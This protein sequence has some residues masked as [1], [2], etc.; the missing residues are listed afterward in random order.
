MRGMG[1]GQG[2]VSGSAAFWASCATAAPAIAANANSATV[3][4]A[5]MRFPLVRFALPSLIDQ[6]YSRQAKLQDRGCAISGRR[7]E[8]NYFE[9]GRAIV[10]WLLRK[11]LE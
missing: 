11:Q 2:V 3:I 7:R 6:A 10:P 5:C 8:D 1:S 4:L 9:G